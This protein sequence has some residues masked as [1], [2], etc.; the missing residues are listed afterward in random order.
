MPEMTPFDLAV[1]DAVLRDMTLLGPALAEATQVGEPADGSLAAKAVAAGWRRVIRRL[2]AA[3][4]MSRMPPSLSPM[5]ARDA[6]RAHSRFSPTR[7]L[8]G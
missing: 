4:P 2:R 8:G 6:L 5:Q 1:A 7:C 3:R